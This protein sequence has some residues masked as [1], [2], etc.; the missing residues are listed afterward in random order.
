MDDVLLATEI[1]QRN[2]ASVLHHQAEDRGDKVAV[3]DGDGHELTYRQLRDHGLRAAG[4]LRDLGLDRQE[5]VCVMLMDH[6][7]RVLLWAGASLGAFIEV[8]INTAY[9]GQLLSHVISNAGATTIVIEGKWCSLLLAVAPDLPTIRTVVVR[10]EADVA[11]PSKWRVLPF[12]DILNAEAIA[13]S[14]TKVNDIAAI[15]HTSG[16]EG[17]S[18]GVLCPHGHAFTIGT[19]WTDLR[20]DDVIMINLPLFHAAGLWNGL[21]ATLI[22]GASAI[23]TGGFSASGF[24]SMVHRFGCTVTLLLGAMAEFL[25]RQPDGEEERANPMRLVCIVPATPGMAEALT[26]RFDLEVVTSYGSTEIGTICN[27]EPGALTP[28]SCGT[29]RSYVQIRLVDDDDVEVPPGVRGEAVIRSTEPW[30]LMNGYVNMSEAT[31]HAWRNLWF[32]T[33]DMLYRDEAGTFYYTGRKHDAIR[34][35]GENISAFEVEQSLTAREDIAEAAV[36]AVASE[37]TEQEIKAFVVPTDGRVLDFADVV[38]DLYDRLPYFMVPRYFESVPALPRTPTLKVKKD[39]LPTTDPGSGWD[40]VRAGFNI[41]RNG[42]QEG[43]R[44]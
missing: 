6:V 22:H 21:Y 4:G 10:G 31:I 1:G 16:T 44:V 27:V 25:L 29:P 13:A 8:P 30:T 38:R 43:Q 35:R 19:S 2:V 24:W 36:V 41:T 42:L 15:I 12:A 23:V 26:V 40:A 20:P 5:T 37:F 14:D 18:K 33:G 3:I 7:D 9:K 17:V 32:H 11:L 34:R 39:E 28:F